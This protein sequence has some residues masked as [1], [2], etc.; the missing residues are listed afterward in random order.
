MPV[1][2]TTA[3]QQGLCCRS[4]W[5]EP[6]D[7]MEGETMMDRR[8]FLKL[9]AAS[10]VT[11][12]AVAGLAPASF[13]EDN[14]G[15]HTD[16]EV[17]AMVAAEL[18]VSRDVAFYPAAYKGDFDKFYVL[19][20][21]LSR[22]QYE[23]VDGAAAPG[24]NASHYDMCVALTNARKALRQ[25]VSDPKSTVW[26][27]WGDQMAVET[28]LPTEGW[29]ISYDNEGFRPFLNP[30]MLPHQGKVK[31]NVI[32]IA[33]GGSTHRNNVVEG[34]PVAEY[35]NKQGYNAFVLQRRV[36][37]YAA[38]DQQLDLARAIRYIRHN[39]SAKN[40]GKTDIMIAVGFSAGGM[41]IMQVIANQFG[42]TNTPDKVYSDYV[43]DA[44]DYESADLNVAIPVYGLFVT[45]LDFTKNPN[46]PPVFGVVG[47]KDSL[48]AMML[49]SL[50]ECADIFKD[51][52]FYLAPDAPHGV[53]LGTGTKGYV[54][55]YTQIA[56]WPEMAVN[57]IESRL[58][59][60]EKTEDMDS[61]A[62]AW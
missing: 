6:A 4:P 26:E 14:T 56:Q 58:G 44:V 20:H 7:G 33:G 17:Q 8:Q 30:Y 41:N 48:S 55:A 27:I 51:F 42:M 62:F 19:F 43:C 13:A 25:V 21:K 9:S 59:L 31:G 18:K 1:W 46:L 57:F 23:K 38:V 47:Q 53:G 37:P 50:P 36:N 10:A 40:I 24:I 45:G 11:A 49:P 54:N 12:S 52:S 16:A 22:A 61:V 2:H 3:P 28:P 35:F 34:Y 29:N 32:I 60:M 39:A 15:V 5:P